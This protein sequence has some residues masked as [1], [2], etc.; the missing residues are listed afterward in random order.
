[1]KH[2]RVILAPERAA[3]LA[4][5]IMCQL[6]GEVHGDLTGK[7]H[8][9]SPVVAADVRELD[10]EKLGGLHLDVVDRRESLLLAPEPSQRLLR[11]L[12][13]QFSP[14]QRPKGEQARE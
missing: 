10:A 12:D 7:R 8:G 5:R 9:A 1:M 13:C 4:E 2:G 11:E 14:T 3:H 6:P